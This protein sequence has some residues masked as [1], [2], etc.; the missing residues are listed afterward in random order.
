MGAALDATRLYLVMSS[1]WR[2]LDVVGLRP[3]CESGSMTGGLTNVVLVRRNGGGLR[4][5]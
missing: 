1:N 2:M 5:G 3:L 4:R